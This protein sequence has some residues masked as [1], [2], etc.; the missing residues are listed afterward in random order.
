MSELCCPL[1]HGFACDHWHQDVRREYQ[2]C[3]HCQLVF[4]PPEFHLGAEDEKAVYDLH[5][6]DSNDEGYRHFLN[7]VTEPLLQRLPARAAGL[8]FGC[9]SGPVLAA[10]L[11]STGRRVVLH[12]K[13]YC[14][15]PV[16]LQAQYDFVTAT[17]VVEHLSDPRSVFQ[18]LYDLLR[19]GA[20]LAIMTKRVR[21]QAAFS[22]WHYIRDLTHIAFYSDATF[23]WIAGRWQFDLTL[24]GPDV[25][26]LQKRFGDPV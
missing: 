14:P 3:R 17:E 8:D 6:N 24:C 16:A 22:H 19:P 15:N 13:F 10:M 18:T 4:V 1:C 26:L 21:N 9:G 25:V 11:E 5:Q 12:D 7:R 20:W 23:G 2:R